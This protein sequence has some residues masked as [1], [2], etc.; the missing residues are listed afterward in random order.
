M[1][2]LA[3]RTLDYFFAEF[4]DTKFFYPW[5]GL[6]IGALW[7]YPVLT[8]ALGQSFRRFVRVSYWCSIVALVI[9]MAMASWLHS[10]T[11]FVAA[12]LLLSVLRLILVRRLLRGTPRLPPHLG[13]H[14][15]AQ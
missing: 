12:S 1:G 7:G 3:M 2:A 11:V 15:Y 6:A 13:L 14:V 5:G 8:T 10:I 4:D 9:S